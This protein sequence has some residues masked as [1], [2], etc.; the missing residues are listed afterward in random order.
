MTLLSLEN[1]LLLVFEGSVDKCKSV[2]MCLDIT[3]HIEE[4]AISQKFNS[5]SL[6]PDRLYVPDVPGVAD[7]FC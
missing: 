7:A 6:P 5:R 1:I 4:S 3:S 2:I